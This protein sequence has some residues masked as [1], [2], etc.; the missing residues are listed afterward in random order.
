MLR[1]MDIDP[2]SSATRTRLLLAAFREIYRCGF[3]AAAVAEILSDTGL[4][5]GALYH[6]FP[7]KHALGL[8]VI[9]EVIQGYL[10]KNIFEPLEEA[11]HPAHALLAILEQRKYAKDDE[12]TARGCPLNNLVQEMSPI[13]ADFREHLSR[14]LGRWES[15]LRVALMKAKEAGEVRADVDCEAAALFILAAWEGCFSVAKS[16]QS[17]SLF[18]EC[19]TQLQGYVRLL[20][21]DATPKTDHAFLS[22]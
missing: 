5:K 3:Q 13:D 9:D 11:P 21:T 22:S 1:L 7:S 18:R 16:R 6:H 17:A 10:A 4:T 20:L 12:S 8:A 15:A 2:D 14:V 19:L